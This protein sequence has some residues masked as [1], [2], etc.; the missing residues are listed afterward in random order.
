MKVVRPGNRAQHPLLVGYVQH[1]GSVLEG[2]VP[3]RQ[4]AGAAYRLVSQEGGNL[5]G[6]ACIGQ[7]SVVGQLHFSNVPNQS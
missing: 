3:R 4:S 5:L 6:R 2:L 1:G 7:A